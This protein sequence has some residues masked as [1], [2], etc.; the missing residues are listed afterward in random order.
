[1]ARLNTAN[2][3]AKTGNSFIQTKQKSV[4]TFEGG[5]GFV[6]T[7]EG[8]LFLIA[9]SSFNE[10][11]FYNTES[12]PEA[13]KRLVP[14][15]FASKTLGYDP[16][17]WF[18]GLVDYARNTANMRT[19]SIIIAAEVAH[20]AIEKGIP[21]SRAVVNASMSRADEPGEFLAY[22]VSNFGRKIP[23]P[24]K[25]GVADAATRLYNEFSVA[26]YGNK[27]GSFSMGD[28]IKLT[29]PT[30]VD[31]IQSK[32][33]K[34][35][36]ENPFDNA[37]LDGLPMLAERERLLG[38]SADDLWDEIS[39]GNARKYG[40]TW[41]NVASKHGLSKEAWESLVPSLGYMALIR[42]LNNFT[43]YGVSEEVVDQINARISD[44]AE[45]AKSK[46]LPFRFYSAYKASKESLDYGRSLSKALELS[47]SN[48]PR[49]EG[50]TLILVDT[51]GSMSQPVSSRSDTVL[52]EVA[53]LFGSS[54]AIRAEDATLVQ[55]GSSSEEVQFKKTDKALSMMSRFK[56][57]G[58]TDTNGALARYWDSSY[59]RVV[60]ITDEQYSGNGSS[61][62][63]RTAGYP[64]TDNTPVYVFNL[65]AYK[66]S[67]ADSKKNMIQLGGLTDQSFGI[68]PTLEKGADAGWPWLDN[69]EK[70]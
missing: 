35:A 55:F 62:W 20:Y 63:G 26:K 53:S 66:A 60:I 30:P 21:G 65:G 51:S 7:P 47:L 22:W 58:G 34:Y 70:V 2:I 46:Q 31:A 56:F 37:V 43:K 49:L 12:T 61:Y 13:V 23:A 8:E 45:I 54:L 19:V 15:V 38:L 11:R 42:N 67:M 57:L 48:T 52:M 18:K 40:V 5:A 64:V 25:R 17:E 41:E 29:H 9:V 33:F 44:P 10:D 28:V 36:I 39:S 6:R 3:K 16:I 59:D 27:S 32:V 24:V 4:S 50:K 14:K 68:I 69:S 1:M